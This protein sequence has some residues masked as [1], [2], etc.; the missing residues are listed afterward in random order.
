MPGNKQVQASRYEIY[1]QN[2]VELLLIKEQN[3]RNWPKER[4]VFDVSKANL[5]NK[6]EV[7][8]VFFAIQVLVTTINLKKMQEG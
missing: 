3:L 2:S 6:D 4:E 7:K 5:Y 1:K 8:T